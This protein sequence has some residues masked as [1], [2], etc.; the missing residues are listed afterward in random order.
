M[1]RYRI[2]F[3]VVDSQSTMTS[4]MLNGVIQELKGKMPLLLT[5]HLKKE[6]LSIAIDPVNWHHHTGENNCSGCRT[7]AQDG[8]E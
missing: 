7:L 6:G 8:Y 5:P 3:D 2:I 4:Q 1:S